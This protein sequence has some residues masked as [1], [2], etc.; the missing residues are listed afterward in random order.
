LTD[1][2]RDKTLIT[3]SHPSRVSMSKPAPTRFSLDVKICGTSYEDATAT[4]IEWAK[5][6]DSRS[7]FAAN[8]HTV[9]EAHDDQQFRDCVNAADLVT[10]DGMPLVWAL[11]LQGLRGA[12]R[13]YGPDLTETVLAAAEAEGIPVGFFGGSEAVLSLLIDKVRKRFPR[14]PVVYHVA[15]PF[16]P[17]TEEEDAAVISDVA[18]SGARILF[19]GLGCPKQE[20][21][22][23]E[24]RNRIPAVMLGVGAAFDFLA[25]TKAQAPDWMQGAGLEWMFRF[26]TE[27]RR[28]WKRYTKHNP[29]FLVLMLMQLMRQRTRT[30][31]ANGSSGSIA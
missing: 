6:G 30:L 5:A 3:S 13:V 21:W 19:V 17:L 22:I 10:P 29:R 14:L 28:L 24:H 11:R 20:R 8:V 9:M 25:G 31:T 26:V 4:V 18:E 23:A 2:V 15:P 27:P 16:R 7:I 12:R 1:L